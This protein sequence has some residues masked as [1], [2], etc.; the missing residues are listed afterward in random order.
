MIRKL[1]EKL[2]RIP[3]G[4]WVLIALACSVF[5]AGALKANSDHIRKTLLWLRPEKPGMERLAAGAQAI[6]SRGEAVPQGFPLA[7]NVGEARELRAEIVRAGKLEE[8]RTF[9]RIDLAF[10]AAYGSLLFLGACWA[11]K[12]V[13]LLAKSACGGVRG[14]FAKIISWLWPLP[15][16]AALFSVAGDL[17]EHF[18]C[19]KM[20][21]GNLDEA[22]LARAASAYSVKWLAAK[23]SLVLGLLAGLAAS[24]MTHSVR[25]E[26]RL[27]W[28]LVMS[29]HRFA[30]KARFSVLI[31]A[32]FTVALLT[33]PGEDI[34]RSV[35]TGAFL[36]EPLMKSAPRP[37]FAHLGW[38][39]VALLVLAG[40]C[41]G[42]A[43]LVLAVR[44]TDAVPDDGDVEARLRRALPIYYGSMPLVAAASSF[45]IAPLQE[46]GATKFPIAQFFAASLAPLLLFFLLP[47]ALVI[48]RSSATTSRRAM[49]PL[50][51]TLLGYGVLAVVHALVNWPD[52]RVLGIVPVVLLVT[53]LLVFG[54]GR[55]SAV[56]ILP[57]TLLAAAAMH[58]KFGEALPPALALCGLGAL[59]FWSADGVRGTDA[60]H[61]PKQFPATDF[62]FMLFRKTA[63]DDFEKK[64]RGDDRVGRALQRQQASG[65]PEKKPSLS[66]TADAAN[67]LRGLLRFCAVLAFIQLVL[68]AVVTWV[69]GFPLAIGSAAVLA[70]GLA[71][72][73]TAGSLLLFLTQATRFPILAASLIVALLC[74]GVMENHAMR[75]LGK[76]EPEFVQ[77]RV[78]PGSEPIGEAFDQWRTLAKKP[79]ASEPPCLIVAAE[80]GG[81][82]AALWPAIVLGTLQDLS[83]QR[84][85]GRP[86]FSSHVFA[87]S[88]VSG[89]SVGAAVFGALCADGR[90]RGKMRER[91]AAI[92]GKDHLAP[93]IGALLYPDFTQRFLPWSLFRDRAS[94]FE[95]SWEDAWGD[96]KEFGRNRLAEPFSRLWKNDGTRWQPALLL[97]ATMV[98]N[99]KRGLFSSLPILT[100]PGG[101]FIDAHDLHAHLRESGPGA[102]AWQD[103]PLSTAAH[104]SARFPLVSPPG[105]LPSGARVVDGGYFENSAAT[106][107]LDLLNGITKQLDRTGA[108]TRIIFL[109]LRYA[110]GP[111][112]TDLP[113]PN[114]RPPSPVLPAEDPQLCPKKNV[115]NEIGGIAGAVLATREARGSYAQDAIFR[116]YLARENIEVRSFTFRGE[117]IPL[118]WSL[119]Q[120][121]CDDMLSQFPASLKVPPDVVEAD[122]EII[123]SNVGVAEWLLEQ[124]YG[125]A[126]TSPGAGQ[127]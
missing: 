33:G 23:T 102:G 119:S 4:G 105:R 62:F 24:L 50:S 61:L 25:D 18:A 12:R 122:R 96:E 110:D 81:I 14:A 89:G 34:V 115:L 20:L 84:G 90:E 7:R 64:L 39:S 91:A 76:P 19:L 41:W 28:E 123:T 27:I 94:A 103:V 65:A 54:L 11:K 43:R 26:L 70:L 6:L 45:A 106:T 32:L 21:D 29:A 30:M 38:F 3:L 52:L 93:A 112:L 31:G 51:W 114:P 55:P 37:D 121:S 78:K 42:W 75:L 82:R 59:A 8:A 85:A 109:F 13:W 36:K 87:I 125:I 73:A 40:T 68:F 79:D 15:A 72:W 58:E 44:F 22:V 35:A 83:L 47:L 97:N 5:G 104:A 111:G 116:R 77:A 69:R 1:W 9:H 17:V 113:P 107:A 48:L 95:R 63:R 53:A 10:M 108:A 80:G 16:V 126:K 98:E 120:R 100:G 117:R 99:G 49:G 74:S 46:I 124:L 57:A 60:L 118:S 88:G 56:L 86:D 101:Q 71:G 127:K 2:R 67:G 92:C 66:L